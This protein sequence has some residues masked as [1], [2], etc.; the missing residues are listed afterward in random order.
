L[1]VPRLQRVPKE[2]WHHQLPVG[3]PESDED[4]GIGAEPIKSIQQV[5]H[6]DGTDDARAGGAFGDSVLITTST[7]RPGSG[8]VGRSTASASSEVQKHH[9]L[10]PHSPQSPT[11]MH[12]DCVASFL[13]S[14][15]LLHST[16]R[17]G[18]GVVGRSTAS[19][20]SEGAMAS[21]V[22]STW[23]TCE[24]DEDEGI[25]AEPIKSIQQV[26]HVDGTDDA[27]A[28]SELAESGTEGCE[29]GAGGAFGDSVLITTS[30]ERPGSGVVG[31]DC[32]ASFLTS[33]RLLHSSIITMRWSI[34]SQSCTRLHR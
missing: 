16:E 19:A 30:T 4:E 22:P 6:V 26:T 2:P 8:V 23:V 11:V 21:S 13:T 25:G 15:R 32:V 28:P 3:S 27:M 29:A 24:S 18:S 20:S 31:P 33:P 7:E 9:Q 17:P 5:T 14:P 10:P 12:P 1:G 34:P